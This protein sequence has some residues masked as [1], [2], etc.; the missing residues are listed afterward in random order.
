[1]MLKDGTRVFMVQKVGL[2]LGVVCML[3]LVSC[4]QVEH[5][6][7]SDTRY[8]SKTLAKQWRSSVPDAGAAP[9]VMPS[10]PTVRN[11]PRVMYLQPLPGGGYVPVYPMD[12]EAD[13]PVGSYPTYS[14]EEDNPT[15]PGGGSQEGSSDY[16]YPLYF[17]K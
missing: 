17:D 6:P 5:E 11:L 9:V 16:Y 10:Q 14:P 1:M 15:Y 13:V 3:F 8:S 4:A 12:N 2:L 7:R